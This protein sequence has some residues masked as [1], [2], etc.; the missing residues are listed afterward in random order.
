MSGQQ[1]SRNAEYSAG[2]LETIRVGTEAHHLKQAVLNALQTPDPR[3]YL[4]VTDPDEIMGDDLCTAGDGDACAKDTII[5]YAD[6]VTASRRD[7]SRRDELEGPRNAL[8]PVASASPTKSRRRR[9]A[10]NPD[11]D[12][13]AATDPVRLLENLRAYKMR[14]GRTRRLVAVP[15]SFNANRASKGFQALNDAVYNQKPTP[16][17]FVEVR[18]AKDA[19][20]KHYRALQRPYKTAK[21]STKEFGAKV[22]DHREALNA[23]AAGTNGLQCLIELGDELGWTMPAERVRGDAQQLCDFFL[24]RYEEDPPDSTDNQERWDLGPLGVEN[25]DVRIAGLEQ[26]IVDS[27]TRFSTD[28]QYKMGHV[29]PSGDVVAWIESSKQPLYKEYVD[30]HFKWVND[31]WMRFATALPTEAN[32]MRQAWSDDKYVVYRPADDTGVDVLAKFTHEVERPRG[33]VAGTARWHRRCLRDALG[34][35][36]F[37]PDKRAIEDCKKVRTDTMDVDVER[38]IR[39]QPCKVRPGQTWR[40]GGDMTVS[41][42]VDNFTDRVRS[43]KYA[44][45]ERTKTDALRAVDR[46]DIAM[47]ELRES[48]GHFSACSAARDAAGGDEGPEGEPAVET[49]VVPACCRILT[50]ENSNGERRLAL[51][52]I[53][54]VSPDMQTYI[55]RRIHIEVVGYQTGATK[56][57]IDDVARRYRCNETIRAL[58]DINPDILQAS[59]LAA[60]DQAERRR[61]EEEFDDIWK[62]RTPWGPE[63][64][65]SWFIWTPLLVSVLQRIGVAIPPVRRLAVPEGCV[66]ASTWD[67]WVTTLVDSAE[68]YVSGSPDAD[69]ARGEL[70]QIY[71]RGVNTDSVESS[72]IPLKVTEAAVD[73]MLRT[74][75]FS[76]RGV[77]REI[78]TLATARSIRVDLDYAQPESVAATI[79]TILGANARTTR[80]DII[81]QSRYA[82]SLALGDAGTSPLGMHPV[83]F[84]GDI[85]RD[86]QGPPVCDVY[87]Q[88]MRLK[89]RIFGPE[90]TRCNNSPNI[91]RTSNLGLGMLFEDVLVE[92]RSLRNDVAEKLRRLG[93]EELGDYMRENRQ[94]LQANATSAEGSIRP[95][96]LAIRDYHGAYMDHY[97]EFRRSSAQE[98]VP[99]YAGARSGGLAASAAP[100]ALGSPPRAASQCRGS[101]GRET[102]CGG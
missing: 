36:G 23:I 16:T 73:E 90:N 21:E 17:G 97:N 56:E 41:E 5:V 46:I 83:V 10:R 4:D 77:L 55:W 24:D 60:A 9:T 72:A 7:P 43:K 93:P 37:R 70:E 15:V 50:E 8:D 48:L 59:Q 14:Q 54:G 45:A 82:Q 74:I 100:R 47:L 39:A 84:V 87:A 18:T 30:L 99:I 32:A 79:D 91:E 102:A 80:A 13:T 26:E 6:D 29:C 28:A 44:F 27:I 68:Q 76:D 40:F 1:S 25:D 63:G 64:T 96:L 34:N 49:A 101:R 89:E 88:P 78:A 98:T 22:R 42:Y 94:M 75:G 38:N 35:P 66:K 12:R 33:R 69:A 19:F 20:D 11:R 95:L 81:S 2:C 61:Y 65:G 92:F 31:Q 57:A 52:T 71:T 62:G 85:V 3:L 51:F 53:P 67:A 86:M 58:Q